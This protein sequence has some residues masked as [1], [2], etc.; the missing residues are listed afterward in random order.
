MNIVKNREVFAIVMPLECECEI[1]ADEYAPSFG[2]VIENECAVFRW[3]V[4]EKEHGYCVD[5]MKR[6]DKNG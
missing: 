5:F 6:G 3:C 1:C 2:E 4:D